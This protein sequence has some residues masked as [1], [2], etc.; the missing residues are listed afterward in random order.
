MPAAPVIMKARMIAVVTAGLPLFA[1]VVAGSNW[2]A[3][4]FVYA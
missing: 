2:A 1:A 4:G 3:V